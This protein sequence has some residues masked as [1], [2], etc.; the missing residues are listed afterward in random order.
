MKWS[1]VNMGGWS[2]YTSGEYVI[3]KDDDRSYDI[4]CSGSL[5]G[6]CESVTLAKAWVENDRKDT[7]TD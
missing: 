3:E 4:F 1:K 5:V 6:N 7:A 2:E